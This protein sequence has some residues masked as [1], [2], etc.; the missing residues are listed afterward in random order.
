MSRSK[1]SDQLPSEEKTIFD[2]VAATPAT[3]VRTGLEGSIVTRRRRVVLMVSFSASPHFRY[4]LLILGE[5]EEQVDREEALTF[6]SRL[7][8]QH[9]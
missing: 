5:G 9:V 8:Q 7:K 6:S 4:K 3:A 2:K 1:I